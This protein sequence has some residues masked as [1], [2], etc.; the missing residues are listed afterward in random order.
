MTDV[1]TNGAPKTVFMGIDDR[2]T[3]QLPAVSQAIPSHLPIFPLY[4]QKGPTTPQLVV[5][6]A[7]TKMYGAESFNLQSPY[8]N[9]ST[10]FANATNEAANQ[11]FVWRVK[12]DDAGPNATI[13]VSIDLLE[14]K[15][16][17]Y[18]RGTD[19]MIQY[20]SNNLPI[21]VAGQTVDGYKAKFIVSE[22]VPGAGNANAFG[23]GAQT[24]GDQT[25]GTTQSARYPLF[26]FEASSF[27]SWGNNAG[28][29]IWAPTSASVTGPNTP[30]ITNLKCYPF[31]IACINRADANSTPTIVNTLTGAPY[32]DFVLKPDTIDKTFGQVVSIQDIF[33]DAYQS[34]NKPGEVDVIGQFGR[35]H[36]YDQ[37]IKTVLDLVYDAEKTYFDAFSDMTGAVNEEYL[38]NFFGG[39]SSNNV[40]YHT[41]QVVLNDVNAVRLS[42]STNIYAKGG[43]DGTMTDAAFATS[44]ASMFEAF[45]DETSY[46]QD[47]AKYPISAVWDSGYPP[48][49]K[50]ALLNALAKRKDIAVFLGTSV[51][52]DA[53]LTTS[54]E[55]SMGQLL[56]A[57]AQ[58]YPESEFYGTSVC[59][60]VVVSRS[61]MLVDGSYKK[62]L[63][64]TYDLLVKIVNY[65]GASDGVWN[66]DQAFDTNP[67][68]LVTTMSDINEVFAPASVRNK[69]WKNGMMWPENSDF[70][71]VYFP[72]FRTVYDNDTSVLNNIFTMMCA[73]ELEKVGD[74][75]RRLFSNNTKLTRPQLLDRVTKEVSNNTVNRFDDRFIILPEAYFTTEDEARGYSYTLVI[76]LGANNSPTVMTL[77]IQTYRYGDLQE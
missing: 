71:S 34:L 35:F 47:M 9:H 26:D 11:M 75:V 48:T 69:D 74:R 52:G 15:I 38:F 59:R 23:V 8:A 62:R 65:M 45:A 39:C 30:Y 43:S 12:P 51:A 3:R 56:K 7:M 50:Y 18:Q 2:S 41:Y 4:T 58:L 13:R 55:S 73:V 72:A 53:K 24:I 44:V 54:Q 14:T 40:P 28:F 64:L 19:G 70:K 77:S 42:D 46:L 76:K 17:V 49:A 10:V 32:I 60:A 22:I 5:G 25:D 31:R 37:N 66:K 68:N 36:A 67:L 61:G 27:G 21:V 6:S 1:I 33:L 63:P 57:R 16:P 29:R 20:D